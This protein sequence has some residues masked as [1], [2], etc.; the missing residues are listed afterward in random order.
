MTEATRC[1]P[2]SHQYH[3]LPREK[4]EERYTDTA[5]YGPRGVTYIYEPVRLF[6]IHCGWVRDVPSSTS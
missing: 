3:P 5:E 4:T 6:C 1:E 2:T